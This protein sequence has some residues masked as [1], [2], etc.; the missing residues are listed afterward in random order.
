[1]WDIVQFIV[2]QNI[3]EAVSLIGEDTSKALCD[4]L[5]VNLWVAQRLK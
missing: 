5:N 1:M 4:Y 2:D 3:F